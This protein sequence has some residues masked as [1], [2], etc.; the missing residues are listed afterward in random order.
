MK[1]DVASVGSYER[2]LH[3][4]I[5]A[6]DV[7]VEL[8]RAFRTLGK[9][10]RMRGF[11]PGKTPRRLLEQRYGP[12]VRSDVANNLI[13]SSYTSA[14][15]DHSI[16]P[17]GQPRLEKSGDLGGNSDFEFT[18]AVDVRPEVELT[19]YTGLDVVYPRVEVSD[20][21]L[22]AAVAE[23]L[24]GQA[25][26]VEITDRAIAAGDTVLT[27]LVATDGDDEVAREPG[28]MIRTDGDSYYAGIEDTLIGMSVG[29]ETTADVTFGADAKAAGV[30]G[31][32]LSTTVKIHSVQATQIP[33]LDDDLAGEMGFEGGAE[34]MRG[35]IQLQ[36]QERRNELARNQARANAL[37]ALIEANA[38]EVPSGMVDQ[39]LQMLT[40]ELK[41]QTAYRSG[42]DPRT[43]TFS[44]AQMADLRGRAVF[45]AKAGLILESVAAKE[46]VEVVDADLDRKYNELA[47]QRGQT[48]EAVRGY[49]MKEGA[50]DEL[51]DRLLEEKTLDWLLE[52]SN[53]VEP[54]EDAQDAPKT[55]LAALAEELIEDQVKARLANQAKASQ[56]AD[57]DTTAAAEPAKPAKKAKAKAKAKAAPA[58]AAKKAKAAPAEPAVDLSKLKVAELKALAAE[59]NLTGYSKLKKAELIELLSK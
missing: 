22:E 8:D 36:L 55:G 14:L 42:R 54:A 58:K 6:K 51:R 29:D 47:L 52:N 59:R 16:E 3:F 25:R 10:V 5:P 9:Q 15:A 34:G 46:S 13:Q 50:V 7:K 38:F 32:T 41:L 18:I 11:R 2:H 40:E 30:A 53:L 56:D 48:V 1:V 17:V 33:E 21:E 49:F 35:A 23:R 28:T 31:R 45:A 39:S 27:E 57:T 44:D 12:Q 43:I 24:A 26:L 19:S 20:A 4:S 37:E